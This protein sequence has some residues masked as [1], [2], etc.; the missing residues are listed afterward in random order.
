MPKIS[1]LPAASSVADA[2]DLPLVQGGTTKRADASLV[3]DYIATYVR[4]VPRI[5]STGDTIT[6]AGIGHCYS[7]TGTM[8]VPASTFAAGDVVSIY[9]N[10]SSNLTLT[11]GASLTLRLSGT[12][13][14]GSRTLAQRSLATIWFESATEAIVIGAGVS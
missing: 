8:T 9:N 10:T 4:N 1:E 11:Q 5:A 2:D 12:A 6:T 7:A 3:R 14:T 13:T